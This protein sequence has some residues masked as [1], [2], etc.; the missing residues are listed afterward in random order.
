MHAEDVLEVF[1]VGALDDL[2]DARLRLACELVDGLRNSERARQRDCEKA[3]RARTNVGLSTHSRQLYSQFD[4][5][6]PSPNPEVV[7]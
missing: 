4:G 7:L 1:V 2:P 5:V 3:S 6:A